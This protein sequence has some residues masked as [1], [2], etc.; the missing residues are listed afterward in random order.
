MTIKPRRTSRSTDGNFAEALC[1]EGE[2]QVDET[3]FEEMSVDEVRR[4]LRDNGLNYLIDECVD[5]P[6]PPYTQPRT[7]FNLILP[8]RDFSSLLERL[9][10]VEH[11]VTNGDRRRESTTGPEPLVFTREGL[12]RYTAHRLKGLAPK[13]QDWIRRADDAVWAVTQGVV[14]EESMT[15]L[16]DYTLATYSSVESHKKILSFATAFLMFLSKTTFN[17][18]FQAHTV[19]LELPKTVKVR[20]AVTGR[21]VTMDD[22]RNVLAYIQQAYDEGRIGERRYHHYAAFVI[23]GA[24][25]GQRSES[26]IGHVTVG[27]FRHAL[28]MEKPV[29]RVEP[30]Q[31]KIRLGHEVPLHPCVV[32][33]V[34]PLL[35]NRDDSE[36]MFEYGSFSM[37]VKRQQISMSRFNGHF[38]LGD[39]RKFAEQ[40]GDII[41]WDQ[42]NRAYILTHGVSGV[43]WTHYKHPL[44]EHVYDVYMRYWRDVI[45]K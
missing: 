14:S 1:N 12:E 10:A 3:K 29:L 36:N 13:S 30:S 32:E 18:Q 5:D 24:L 35:E 25:T 33:V 9:S 2:V 19:F 38:V 16:R 28:G 11:A 26:T 7:E 4:L 23:F 37:W 20:K 45:F 15:A 34:H 17:Q 21:I 42:S 44:P 41:G 43:D 22:I 31:D 39:L 27:Q 40:H 8:E 6:E